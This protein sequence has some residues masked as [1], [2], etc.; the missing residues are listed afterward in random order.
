MRRFLVALALVLVPN[1]ALAASQVVTIQYSAGSRAY[2]F[3]DST[4]PIMNLA[5][6][7]SQIASAIIEATTK[8]AADALASLE[9]VDGRMYSCKATAFLIVEDFL[10]N[11]VGLSKLSAKTCVAL[12]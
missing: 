2:F 4:P 1:L 3:I 5:T 12:N 6:P 11:H 7:P 8:K 9:K 10:G